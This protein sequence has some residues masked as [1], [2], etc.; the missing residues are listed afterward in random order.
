MN[1]NTLQHQ[2]YSFRH[3]KSVPNEQKLI[4]SNVER[5]CLPEY[6]LVE[7]GRE[8]VR[9]SIVAIQDS[10]L[11]R[12]TVIAYSPFQRTQESTEEANDLLQHKVR[13]ILSY[14]LRERSFGTLENTSDENYQTVWDL[15]MKNPDHTV[16][17]VE[18]IIAVQRRMLGVI[19]ILETFISKP[20]TILLC[21]HGDPLQILE[22]AFK[23]ISPRFHRSLTPLERG[24]IRLLNERK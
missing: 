11:E 19:A 9:A 10:L 5:G 13:L 3:G 12:P 8:Q 14:A 15:D 17:G 2:Y 4:I 22:T 20:S 6:G 24:E 21:S 7:E 23:E 18:S 16:Y 1:L